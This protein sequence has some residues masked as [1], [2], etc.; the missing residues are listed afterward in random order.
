[1]E[2]KFQTDG[3]DITLGEVAF[4]SEELENR[5]LESDAQL[6]DALVDIF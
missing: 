5:I 6:E 3:A 2:A 4:W 1:M